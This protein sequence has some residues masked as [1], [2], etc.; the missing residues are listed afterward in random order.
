MFDLLNHE[1][2]VFPCVCWG[3]PCCSLYLLVFMWLLSTS[4]MSLT[5]P[6][7]YLSLGS[8]K[9]ARSFPLTLIT[10]FSLFLFHTHRHKHRHTCK[11]VFLLDGYA[12][13]KK[14]RQWFKGH[15]SCTW[16]RKLLVSLVSR[17]RNFCCN[18][19]VVEHN[20]EIFGKSSEISVHYW[21]TAAEALPL[22]T[23]YLGAA[24]SM[25]GIFCLTATNCWY[26]QHRRISCDLIAVD[27]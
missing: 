9:T 13:K 26:L 11:S 16:H 8:L 17:K 23:W 15:Y 7:M 4:E 22:D 1:S 20:P 5:P 18:W 14:N 19:R 27:N 6:F 21:L 3:F 24:L 12:I 2:S 10:S 25:G